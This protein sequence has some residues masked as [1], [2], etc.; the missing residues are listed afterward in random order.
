MNPASGQ[1]GA[2]RVV[3]QTSLFTADELDDPRTARG[4]RGPAVCQIV[5][6]TYRQLDYWARTE[7]VQPSL[8]QGAGSGTQ[9][10]Y[11]FADMLVLRVVK[12]LLA[13]GVSLQSIR[14]AVEYLRNRGVRDL[15]QVT[16]VSDGVTIYEC[17]GPEDIVDLLQRGQG[18]FGVALGGA[19]RDILGVI[20]AAPTLG[21]NVAASEA[22]VIGLPVASPRRAAAG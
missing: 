1:A 4:Y 13:T 6:I 12:R 3:G 14:V 8:R 5:G 2:G 18:V 9:R 22:T 17:Q 20:D 15:A 16:L 19:M 7:L 11:S 21:Q 10:L